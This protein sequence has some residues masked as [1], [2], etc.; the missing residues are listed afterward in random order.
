MIWNVAS[1]TKMIVTDLIVVGSVLLIGSPMDQPRRN[2]LQRY[3]PL[4]MAPVDMP[5]MRVWTRRRLSRMRV[6]NG[7]YLGVITSSSMRSARS[8]SS[9][10]KF[11]KMSRARMSEIV[12]GVGAFMIRAVIIMMSSA[13]L[14][15]IACLENFWWLRLMMRP[16]LIPSTIELKLFLAMATVPCWS[17]RT[18]MM[19]NLSSFES[20]AKI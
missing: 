17:R 8:A 15:E 18:F 3:M 19:R 12:S 4:R 1:R 14:Q 13:S 7:W 9:R 10:V 2:R 5:L 6:F 20:S 16:F 11:M